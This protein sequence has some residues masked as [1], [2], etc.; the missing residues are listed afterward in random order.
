MQPF[1]LWD[2]T[3]TFPIQTVETI[4]FLVDG[5]IDSTALD[6]WLMSLLWD[7]TLVGGVSEENQ[8]EVLRLKALL[9]VKGSGHKLVAQGVRELYDVQEAAPW[10]A[11]EVRQT[12]MVVIGEWESEYL[13]QLQ[14]TLL[15]VGRN[16]RNC[17]IE[18]SF[19]SCCLV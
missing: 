7:R 11:G 3:F 14:L 12:K 15:L 4:T 18:Q 17:P 13:I 2:L 6:R 1:L 10:L 9:N 19:R 8:L 16:L 5:E